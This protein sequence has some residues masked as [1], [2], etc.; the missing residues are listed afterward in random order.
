MNEDL[1]LSLGESLDSN[2]E[3][4]HFSLNQNV[5]LEMNYGKFR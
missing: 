2:S 5:R 4:E 3:Q 1:S